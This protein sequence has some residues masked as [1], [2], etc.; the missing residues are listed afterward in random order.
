MRLAVGAALLGAQVSLLGAEPPVF[1][2]V[3]AQ[4]RG[5][6]TGLGHA[7]RVALAVHRGHVQHDQQTLAARRVAAQI[8]VGA[9]PGVVGVEPAQ[10][11]L[12]VVPGVQGWILPVEFVQVA[13][14]QHHAPVVAQVGQVPGQLGIEIP[15]GALGEFLAHEQQLLAG[16]GPHVGVEGS[17][18]RHLGVPVAGHLM[19]QA[20]LAVDHLVVRQGQHELLGVAVDVVEGQFVVL[21]LPIDRVLFDVGQRVVHPAHRPLVGKAQAVGRGGGDTSVVGALLGDNH[22]AGHPVGHHIIQALEEGRRLQV[23]VAA[24]HIGNPVGAREVQVEHRGHRVHPQAVDVVFLQPAQRRADQEHHDLVA[25]IIEDVGVP[26]VVKAAPGVGVFVQRPAVEVGQAV[27]VGGE[28]ARHPVEQHPDAARVQVIDEV[29]EVVGRAEAGG[30]RVVAGHLIAPGAVEGVLHDA[31]QLDGGV[32]EPD[33]VVGQP[34]RQVAVIHEPVVEPACPGAQVHL[35]DAD[36]RALA[37]VALGHP[38]FV[39]PHEVALPDDA[40]RR[41]AQFGA[42]HVRIGFLDGL[43]V[44]SGDAVLV[45]VSGLCARHEEAPEAELQALH[46]VFQAVPGVEVAD[47]ADVLG[48]RRPEREAH[49]GHATLGHQVGAQKLIGAHQVRRGE[50]LKQVVTERQRLVHEH[51]LPSSL[52]VTGRLPC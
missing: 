11:L 33:H 46:R 50:L 42:G 49:T 40:G 31:H 28:M 32:A 4:Q 47:H 48:I 5:V 25:A 12:G 8:A 14:Q 26:V 3:G 27:L 24:E 38:L 7:Q 17:Q 2:R 36:R 30:G 39:V 51:S 43:A 6:L 13:H 45:G 23:L 29:F 35:V 9:G 15:F 44:L 37:L 20:A 34:V 1:A 19:Q 22:G 41:R 52:S 18:A 16:R 10:A 21:V